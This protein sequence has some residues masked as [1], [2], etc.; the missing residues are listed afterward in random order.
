MGLINIGEYSRN[1]SE[2]TQK[3]FAN[4][5][6]V[7]IRGLRNAAAHGYSVLNME[8]I[9]LTITS[10]IPELETGLLDA[11]QILQYLCDTNNQF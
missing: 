4:I 8:D 2:N 11:L 6:W 10:S 7:K 1:V 5:P 9:W 3:Q